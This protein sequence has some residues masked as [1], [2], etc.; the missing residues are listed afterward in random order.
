[1]KPPA[2]DILSMAQTLARRLCPV[3]QV[4]TD[5]VIVGTPVLYPD[6]GRVSLYLSSDRPGL[7]FVSDFEGG[8]RRALMAGK[9]AAAVFDEFVRNWDFDPAPVVEG[10]SVYVRVP[11][12][13]LEEA[14]VNVAN[15]SALAVR[16]ALA[17][18]E[19]DGGKTLHKT[20]S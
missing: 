1:M 11:A 7:W 13:R 2:Q 9:T 18:Q 6:G 16:A 4:K 12:D 20:G 10:H 14:A 15:L 19:R 3:H 8:R 5:G 17:R